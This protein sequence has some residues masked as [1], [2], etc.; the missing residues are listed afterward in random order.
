MNAIKRSEANARGA[1]HYHQT[2]I[3]P[4]TFPGV[5]RLGKG[6]V[7][8]SHLL[9]SPDASRPTA[10]PS[11]TIRWSTENCRPRGDLKSK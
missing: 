7:N 8:S 6:Q 10:Q 4:E 2:R 9:R 1:S 3:T 11:L 5:I